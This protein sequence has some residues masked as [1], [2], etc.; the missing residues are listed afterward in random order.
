MTQYPESGVSLVA[1]LSQYTTAMQSAIDLAQQWDDLASGDHVFTVST[2][3]DTSGLDQIA[4]LPLSDETVDYT[5]D[6]TETGDDIENLPQDGDNVG[7]NVDVEPTEETSKL[8]DFVS[9]IKDAAIST[10]WNLAGT[11]VDFIK[12]IGGGAVQNLFDLDTA[13]ARL[14]ATTG[15]TIPEADTLINKIF[16]SDLGNS[17]DQVANVVAKAHQLNLPL[18]DAAT[19]ALRFTK[20]FPDNDPTKV[21]NT[22]SQLVNAHI[23]PDFKTASDYLVAAFQDG[24]N[25]AGDLLNTL[26]KNATTIHDLGLTGP[27]SLSFIKTGLD[28]GYKSAQQVI[29]SLTKI[30]TNIT[31][32]SGNSNSDVT[33]TLNI[34]GIANPVD[35]GQAW[36][37]DF[38]KQVIAGIQ[39]APVS[40]AE[41]EKM[42]SN[43]VGGKVGSQTFSAFLKLSPDQ[44]DDVL[45]A[46]PDA[47]KRAA[48]AMD[49]SLSGSIKDFE[50][51]LQSKVN[52]FL[53][54]S[55]VDLPGKIR[56]LKGGLQAALDA[57]ATGG[58]LQNAL[59]IA[60]KPLGFDDDFQHLEAML[61][62]FIIS[63]LQV[64]STLQTLTGHGDQ[65]AGTNA[66]IADLSKKQLV[67]DLK[68]GNPTDIATT[69]Q[70]AVARGVSPED[71]AKSAS[72]AVS[73]LIKSGSPQ[74][75]Q[76]LVN[77]IGSM[78]GFFGKT[79][80]GD[81]SGF[82]I[83]PTISKDAW[84]SLQ[85][86]IDDNLKTTNDANVATIKDAGLTVTDDLKPKTD[87]LEDSSKKAT[88]NLTDLNTQTTAQ[89]T[90]SQAA[91]TPVRNV[92]DA[93]Q[94]LGD[95]AGDASTNVSDIAGDITDMSTLA[96]V[97]ANGLTALNT[98]ILAIIATAKTLNNTVAQQTPG[99]GTNTQPGK[100]H[101]AG[102]S[103]ATG[104][105][106][107][108]ENGPEI[109]TTNKSLAVLNNV[110]SEAIMS[111]LSPY[112]PS[113]G[114]SS[115]GGGN[116][117]TAVNYNNVQNIPQGDAVG[118]RTSRQ[119]RGMAQ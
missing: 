113:A 34:L 102:T 58:D 119:L 82:D 46:M 9:T 83:K 32:A 47:A 29:D 64:V 52:D 103:D 92:A 3:V 4:D 40:D 10:V 55:S 88:K 99:N 24:D 51:G 30:K 100:G 42:F 65:A 26:N 91:V 70:G 109:V 81:T 21:M 95:A 66:T 16:Y 78:G 77:N 1:D 11:G 41:K 80:I 90:K 49:D 59:T 72:Q 31:N 7:V 13:M 22:M 93:T 36:S 20:V 75:A 56:A 62:N 57:L 67:F 44:A 14:K 86:Q 97:A 87:A 38:F 53:T 69:I 76:E 23:V 112:T 48:D 71:I 106:M 54:S 43:L 116:S 104:T 6:V 8:M 68:V 96:P 27:E 105:F 25:K 17:V 117:Y 73:E 108:G 18:E 60:L 74:A 12:D 15:E 61:G 5:V 114:G 33:K 89:N 94:D 111:A 37:A 28:N 2:E 110:T 39:N 118:Y 107:T 115:K 98:A 79:S 84:N 45:A 35:T 101:A 85:Q 63:I 50:L 19:A